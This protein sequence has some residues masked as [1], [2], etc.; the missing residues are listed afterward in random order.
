VKRTES[1]AAGVE[2]QSIEPKIRAHHASGDW[3]Q[4]AT[5]GI[6]HYGA[7]LLRFSMAMM[8][9]ADWAQEVFAQACERIWVGIP[10]FRF[11][12]SFRTWAFTIVRR[13]CIEHLRDPR[14]VRIRPLSEAGPLSEIEQQVRTQTLPFL[15]DEVKDRLKVLRES[16]TAQQQA[17]LTLRLDRGLSW[18]EIAQVMDDELVAGDATGLKRSETALRKQFERL[19]EQ[20][21]EL[22]KKE[23]LL[24]S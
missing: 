7:E 4:V 16:L 1:T 5:V 19:K 12:C 9:N 13:L 15:R 6:G 11:D 10:D 21:R 3:R 23:G 24:D 14:P 2:P 18:A 8:R 17:L 22:A 20:L